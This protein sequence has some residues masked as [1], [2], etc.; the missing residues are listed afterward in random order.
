MAQ[1]YIPRNKT[2]KFSEKC[3]YCFVVAIA[4]DCGNFSVRNTSKRSRI[5]GRKLA[6]VDDSV[7]KFFPQ[8]QNSPTITNISKHLKMQKKNLDFISN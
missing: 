2:N 5:K 7:L 3:C 6:L 8:T 1:I 4:L